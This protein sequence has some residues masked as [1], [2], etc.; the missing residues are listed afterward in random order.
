MKAAA[1]LAAATCARHGVDIAQ[2]ALQF[3]VANPDI[4]T[5]VAGSANPEN[6]RKW[7]KWI[8]EPIDQ[9][10]LREVQTIFAPVKNMGHKEGLPENT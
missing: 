2:L 10:L 1:R 9:D 7:A 3:S 8:A 4:T 6:I 5:T